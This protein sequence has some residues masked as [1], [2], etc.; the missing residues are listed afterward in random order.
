MRRLS[1]LNYAISYTQFTGCRIERWSFPANFE[2]IKT[3]IIEETL[4]VDSPS[5]PTMCTFF[6]A[7]VK[8]LPSKNRIGDWVNLINNYATHYWW[9]SCPFQFRSSYIESF[10]ILANERAQPYF[11][12][13]FLENVCFHE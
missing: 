7:V 3:P 6:L 11:M 13:A 1:L 5:E 8:R 4:P 9:Y 12:K 2:S 10:E